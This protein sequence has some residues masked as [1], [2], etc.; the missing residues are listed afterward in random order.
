MKAAF[1]TKF[2]FICKI[3][4]LNINADF[5]TLT[6]NIDKKRPKSVVSGDFF[7]ALLTFKA[8]TPQNDQTRS[9]SL[10]AKAEELFE[11]VRPFCVVDA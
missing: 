2:N 10:S 11:C 9:N 5:V 6:Y 7:V 4:T 1:I 3:Y 8:P